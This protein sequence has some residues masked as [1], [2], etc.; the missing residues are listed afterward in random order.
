[1]GWNSK[2][3]IA[4]AQIIDSLKILIVAHQTSVRI[5]T[6]NK[7]NNVAAFDNLDVRNYFCE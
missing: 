6:P 5:G 4:S 7:A 1:M 3:D 2:F